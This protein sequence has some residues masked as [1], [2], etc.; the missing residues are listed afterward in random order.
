MG[1]LFRR[2]EEEIL[3]RFES[4][5]L[6]CLSYIPC[7]KMHEHTTGTNAP[8]VPETDLVQLSVEEA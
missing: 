2:G 7:P 6:L 1:L 5:H 3:E 4:C 8:L